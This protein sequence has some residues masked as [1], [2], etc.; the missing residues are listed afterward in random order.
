MSHYTIENNQSGS[1]NRIS[2]HAASQ[3]AIREYIENR[4]KAKETNDKYAKIMETAF[5]LS[6]DTS[7]YALQASDGLKKLWEI[8]K[9]LKEHLQKPND[10]STLGNELWKAEF[11][12]KEKDLDKRQEK[13]ENG[14]DR[15]KKLVM[16]TR[17]G[18][19]G[20]LSLTY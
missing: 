4:T 14:A 13:I 12:E 9:Q 8:D 15:L 2:L 18:K 6:F 16:K 3:D 1:V 19:P 17:A 10:R 5:S 7:S 11:A 20:E